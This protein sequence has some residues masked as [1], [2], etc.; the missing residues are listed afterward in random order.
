MLPEF[1]SNGTTKHL[2]IEIDR[3]MYLEVNLPNSIPIY[4]HYAE[5]WSKK[6]FRKNDMILRILRV[7]IKC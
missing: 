6:N 7:L 2:L 5:T 1:M 4:G 3:L